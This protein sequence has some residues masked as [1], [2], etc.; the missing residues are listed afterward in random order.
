MGNVTGRPDLDVDIMYATGD[1]F[2]VS[3]GPLLRSS[4]W[5][6]GTW[7]RYATSATEDFVVELSDGID[8]A[9]FLWAPSEDYTPGSESGPENNWTNYQVRSTSHAN[10]VTMWSGGV[11]AYFKVFETIPLALGVRS[12]STITYA[13]HD[14]LYVSENGLFCN[15]STVELGLAGIADPV[16]VG[17]VSAVPST[18]NGN[19]LGVDVK[20]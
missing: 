2:Q 3:A 1:R 15:D 11:R 16:L 14:K 20:F 7:V 9:G 17:I 6:G 18:R 4:G 5:R 13:L 19:R 12:S 8:A 10:V